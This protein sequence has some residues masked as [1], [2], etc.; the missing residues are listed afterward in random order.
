MKTKLWSPSK[1]A[2]H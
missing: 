2:G 1:Q